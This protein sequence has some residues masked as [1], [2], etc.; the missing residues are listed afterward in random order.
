MKKLLL[1]N[2]LLLL[3]S[4]SAF[5]QVKI[6]YMNPNEVM[7]QLPEVAL[8]EQQ[9]Q[10]LIDLRDNELVAKAAQLQ[11]DFVAF[12]QQAAQL[13]PE[14]QSAQQEALIARNDELEAERESYLNEI[15]QRRVTLLQPV[16]TKLE[17]AIKA[18]ADSLNIDLVLN[19]ATSYGDTIISY[20]GFGSIN[21]SSLVLERITSK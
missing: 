13:S 18:V 2:A 15:R 9:I 17:N 20:S 5:A 3:I 4:A 10:S 8:I 11:Q 21:I 14:Q 16:N 12:E 7:A 19:E 6:G 1:F